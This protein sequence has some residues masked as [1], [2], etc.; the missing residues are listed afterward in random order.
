M[1]FLLGHT[2]H[3]HTAAKLS[4]LPFG[5]TV[6]TAVWS[7]L[8]SCAS[9]SSAIPVSGGSKMKH[10]RWEAR[11]KR[12]LASAVKPATWAVMLAS[13]SCGNLQRPIT[14]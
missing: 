12:F 5:G 8:S 3:M 7:S 4:G 13:P 11:G 10:R 6:T 1:Q 14:A 2:Q 9:S